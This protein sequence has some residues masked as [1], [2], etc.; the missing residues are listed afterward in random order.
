MNAPKHLTAQQLSD[1]WGGSPSAATLRTWRREG[2]GPKCFK[3]GEG[4]T[5]RVLY[6]LADVVRYEEERKRV[7]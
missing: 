3:M 7:S 6:A 2:R 1:R 4:K 5:S